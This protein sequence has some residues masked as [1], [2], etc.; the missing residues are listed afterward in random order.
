M[1]KKNSSAS[2]MP[3]LLIGTGLVLIIVVIL[4]QA[5]ANNVSNNPGISQSNGGIP[6]TS[7]VDAKKAYDNGSALFLDV[8]DLEFYSDEHVKGS[9]NI[10]YGDL[11]LRFRQLDSNRWIITYCTWP[12]E[13]TSALAAQ[14]LR[15]K[16]FKNVTALKGGF[17]A[18][19]NAGYPTE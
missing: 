6:R 13:E 1:P 9:I 7:L 3:L 12:N 14:V 17:A 8:R 19:V 4:G 15:S 11:D 5:I 18:W 2:Y 10:P 16:G